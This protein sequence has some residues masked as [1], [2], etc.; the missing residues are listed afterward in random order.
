MRYIKRIFSG[1]TALFLLL[2]MSMPVIA[3]SDT[4]EYKYDA[5]SALGAAT[6]FHMFIHNDASLNAHCFGNIAVGNLVSVNSTFGQALIK[7]DDG[8]SV[9]SNNMTNYIAKLSTDFSVAFYG[10]PVV[11]GKGA[12]VV[13]TD[14]GNKN[15]VVMNGFSTTEMPLSD[16][17]ILVEDD[18]TPF[19]NLDKEFENLKALS[20]KYAEAK[21]TDGVQ[22]NFDMNSA[23]IKTSAEG[24]SVKNIT[25]KDTIALCNNATLNVAFDKIEESTLI[26]NV[27]LAGMGDEVSVPVRTRLNGEGNK[28]RCDSENSKILWNF[29]DS[30]KEDKVYKG[31]LNFPNEWVGSIMAP[32]AK[33]IF[34]SNFD[35][36]LI[37]DSCYIGGES[38]SWYYTGEVLEP[39]TT[40]TTT[41]NITTTTSKPTTATTTT[42]SKTTTTTTEPTTTTT[43]TSN[44]TTTTSKPTTATTT[45]TSKTTTTTTKPTTTTTTTSKTTTT[46]T[47]PTTTTTTTSNI[48]TTVPNPTTTTTTTTSEIATTTPKAATT[49]TTVATSTSLVEIPENPTE[50]WI[51]KTLAYIDERLKNDDLTDEEVE[52]LENLKR[53]L[54][55]MIENTMPDTGTE[56]SKASPVVFSGLLL[57]LGLYGFFNRKKL[58][59]EPDKK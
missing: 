32:G 7:D 41:S 40:T 55:L 58:I 12:E 42:T 30:S 44:I 16:C 27:D 43:T 48:T 28:E 6:G 39:T 21:N 9:R 38:H 11:F 59:D 2:S 50:D 19:I 51:R 4:V 1:L 15:K 14:N 52:E 57:A 18:G 17:T 25:F 45:T 54:S 56:D 47:K 36:T 49:T 5:D 31:T 3:V 53:T 22:T 13:L 24:V 46:T 34:N 26:V 33:V 29:Y 23:E 8:N 35:G 20:K 37:A 10:N